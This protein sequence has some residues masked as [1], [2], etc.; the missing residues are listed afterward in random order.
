MQ[1]EPSKP[2]KI[3]RLKRW[4]AAL[5]P[6]VI[7][8]IAV[9]C[10]YA[11][12]NWRWERAWENYVE[13]RRTAGLW[14]EGDEPMP[15]A[16]DNFAMIPLL[17][18]LVGP[19]KNPNR[20]PR[21]LIPEEF[22]VPAFR[23]WR[24]NDPAGN[25]IIRAFRGSR[26][27]ARP[28][29]LQALQTY[30]RR[31]TN[32]PP[33]QIHPRALVHYLAKLKSGNTNANVI[34]PTA[35][36]K[37]SAGADVLLA[38]SIYDEPIAQMVR[39]LDR[40]HARFQTSFEPNGVTLRHLATGKSIMFVMRTRATAHIANGSPERALQEATHGYLIALRLTE[41]PMLISFL[42]RIA[43]LDVNHHGLWEGLWYR[44][45]N[46]D[47][48]LRAQRLL[49]GIDLFQHFTV[50]LKGERT[51][52]ER[53][54]IL[55]E[56]ERKPMVKSRHHNQD[57]GF[58]R[59]YNRFIKWAPAGWF[60][61]GSLETA[62]MFDELEGAASTNR[63]II[64]L[65]LAATRVGDWERHPSNH[66]YLA[67]IRSSNLGKHWLKVCRAQT[68]LN[69]AI[70]AC[71]LE[72]FYLKHERYPKGLDELVPEYLQAVPIDHADG[73]ALRYRQSEDGRYRVYSV[74]INGTDENGFVNPKKQSDEW[75][76][77]YSRE[78]L[79]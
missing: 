44:S 2:T 66:N 69:Q 20:Q 37:Q 10:F 55:E 9:G 11:I 31:D 78:G 60:R 19:E 63:S 30:Y 33:D 4:R 61:A 53:L 46:E 73:N 34:F 13:T 14:L 22:N 25:G 39:A 64:G 7:A 67:R 62:L 79:E 16:E 45:W 56:N 65:P 43:C 35:P 28:I 15:P 12:E 8:M 72:R 71:A 21:F 32:F 36:S 23:L 40:P 59:E 6:I 52:T 76:W 51:M 18:S 38:L 48:L 77:R 29:D 41:D 74:G 3:S 57:P 26:Q 5:I 24:T 42:V 68:E 75:V 47:Q 70:T 17:R 50:C 1:P 49:A 27:Q 58:E 54:Y